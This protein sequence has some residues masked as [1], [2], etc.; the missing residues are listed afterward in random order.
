MKKGKC[1]KCQGKDILKISLYNPLSK[2]LNGGYSSSK[3]NEDY[4]MQYVCNDCGYVEFWLDDS[5]K[6]LFYKKY[7]DK[8]NMR[9]D[10]S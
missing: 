1:P 6:E 9:N 7:K 2:V 8:K 10:S 5:R 3:Y 4:M